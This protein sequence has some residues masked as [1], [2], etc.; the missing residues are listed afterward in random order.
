LQG[1]A[2]GILSNDI[3]TKRFSDPARQLTETP[4]ALATH[5]L[6]TLKQMLHQF[7][8]SPV[9]DA[10]LAEMLSK[11]HPCLDDL[12]QDEQYHGADILALV[13][14]GVTLSTGLGV[15]GLYVEHQ[16][17]EEFVFYIHAE[18]YEVDAA[19]R[20]YFATLLNQ[21]C[22]TIDKQDKL[23]FSSLNTIAQLINDGYVGIS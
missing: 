3:H 13:N 7:I 20:V 23:Q 1:I 15:K 11:R 9:C 10:L 2:D 8:D 22:L 12:A 6:L 19:D 5:D 21:H 16:T 18:R 17:D 4:A 14:Q